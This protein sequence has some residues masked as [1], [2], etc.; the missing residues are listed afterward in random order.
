MRVHFSGVVPYL[1]LRLAGTVIENTGYGDNGTTL[2]MPSVLK[3]GILD[4]FALQFSS[5]EN[6]FNSPES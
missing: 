1:T 2:C 5:H 6:R 4:E 3:Q